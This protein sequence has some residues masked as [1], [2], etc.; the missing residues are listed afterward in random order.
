MIPRFDIPLRVSPT[1]GFAV[2]EQGGEQDVAACVAQLLSTPAGSRIEVI[3]YGIPDPTFGGPDI[4]AITAAITEW[5]PRCTA[6]IGVVV[7]AAGQETA[8]QM[9]VTLRQTTT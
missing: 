8:Q 3:D 9:T 7:A 2:V 5:E 6:D 1:G 4:E